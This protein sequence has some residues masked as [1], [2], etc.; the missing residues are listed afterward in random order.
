MAKMREVILGQSEADVQRKFNQWQ[1]RMAGKVS[2][3][4]SHVERIEQPQGHLTKAGKLRF[5]DTHMM[6]VKYTK[7]PPPKIQRR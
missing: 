4:E 3:V 2:E 6:I 7:K 1:Q 5:A